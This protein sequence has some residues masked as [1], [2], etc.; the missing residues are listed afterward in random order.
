MESS[1]SI[2]SMTGVDGGC[3]LVIGDHW[4]HLACNLHGFTED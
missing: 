2:L 1:E 4:D 3:S